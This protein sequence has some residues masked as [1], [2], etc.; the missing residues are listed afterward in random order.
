MR[1]PG[2]LE[3]GTKNGVLTEAKYVKGSY[4]VFSTLTDRDNFSN[5]GCNGVLVNGTKCYVAAEGLEYRWNGKQW[6]EGIQSN[7][8]VF[9]AGNKIYGIQ[10]GQWVEITVDEATQNTLNTLTTQVGDLTSQIESLNNKVDGIQDSITEL[11]GEVVKYTLIPVPVDPVTLSD[12]RGAIQSIDWSEPTTPS[13]TAG[14]KATEPIRKTIRLNNYDS[15]S[16]FGTG[17]LANEAFNLAMVSKWNI[18]D[19]GSKDIHLN[20]NTK[21]NITIN[22]SDYVLTSTDKTELEN[23]I[24]AI[25]KPDLS[26]YYTKQETNDQIQVAVADAEHIHFEVVDELPDAGDSNVIYLVSS[27][28]NTY[29]EYIWVDNKWDSIGTTSEVDLSNYSTTAEMNQAIEAAIQGIDLNN[30]YTKNES[31]DLIAAKQDVLVSGTNIKTI[32]GIS[33]LGEGNITLGGG[34]G[35]SYELPIATTEV[36]GGIKS[37]VQEEGIVGGKT[38]L[39]TVDSDTGVASVTVPVFDSSELTAEIQSNTSAIAAN[40]EAINSN[41]EAIE[42][43]STAISSL[44]SNIEEGSIIA[45]KA[46]ADVDG[47][48]IVDT[49]ATKTSVETGLASKQDLINNVTD[50]P[51]V[52]EYITSVTQTDGQISVTR[53]SIDPQSLETLLQGLDLTINGGDA[54]NSD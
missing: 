52:G 39:V 16:G 48:S 51:V 5:L 42:T 26:N 45:G 46:D 25:S 30:Y 1:F 44:Q 13:L 37:G 50:T 18:A 10:N 6:S 47:N 27:A 31:D 8:P 43:N 12:S 11:N 14:T 41:K 32:N 35:G 4:I 49:Y 17:E 21:D 20:L 29:N 40:T 19:F 2:T 34:G 24:A 53:S 54:S 23:Q 22:D 7:V 9:P 36:L 38:V 28:N 15:L 33:L 3:A